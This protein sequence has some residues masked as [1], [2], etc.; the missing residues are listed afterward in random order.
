[1][2]RIARIPI[3]GDLIVYTLYILMRL[4]TPFHFWVSGGQRLKYGKCIIWTPKNRKQ[5]IL[6]GIEFLRIH[7]SEMFLCLTTKQQLMIFYSET[8]SK[9]SGGR[10]YALQEQYIKWGPE[11]IATSMVIA[12]FMYRASRKINRF[13]LNNDERAAL[14]AV[15]QMVLEWMYKHSIQ[16]KLID[17]YRRSSEKWVAQ[18]YFQP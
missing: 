17:A 5:A 18:K 12:L 7:D 8:S 15:P 11:G 4:I 1:M 6:D 16:A 10:I 3:I 2:M 9:N 13:R 14:Q